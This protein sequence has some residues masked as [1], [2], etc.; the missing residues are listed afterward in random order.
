MSV[1]VN[2]IKKIFKIVLLL[3]LVV[4]GFF[5]VLYFMLPVQETKNLKWGISFSKFHA[6]E[7]GLDWKKAYLDILNELEVKRVRLS[8]H[9]TQIEPEKDKYSFQDLDF[10]IDE[11]QKN[12]VSV[13]LALGRRLPGWPECHIP[14]W[15]QNQP[16]DQQRK[17]ILELIEILVNRYK[18]R[19]TIINWQVENEYFFDVFARSACPESNEDFLE[20]EIA[21]VKELDP[22]R[23]VILTD[24]GEF[25]G[26]YSAY[27]R[28]DIFGS[29]LYLY[30][31]NKKLG[32]ISYPIRPSFF[33]IR[34]FLIDLITFRKKSKIVSELQAEP[35]EPRPLVDTQIETQLTHFGIDRFENIINFSKKTGFDTFYL[36]GA[37]WWYWMK[38]NGHPEF[39]DKVKDLLK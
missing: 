8:A 27:K 3:I 9:W 14:S 2:L 38:L 39:W 33:V 13:I 26:W 20:S 37:E 30:V 19:E 21:L 10:Q 5:I 11:A 29:S 34:S 15:V 16:E 31:W 12:R 6:E 32:Y 36:W 28:A 18:N 17:E 35:W 24:S 7:L 25:G 22:S 23:P 1:G 4:I